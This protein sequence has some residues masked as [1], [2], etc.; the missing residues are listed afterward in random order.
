[1]APLVALILVTLK[2]SKNDIEQK[3]HSSIHIVKLRERVSQGRSLKGPCTD[4]L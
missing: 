1:M 4:Y 3:L 2:N